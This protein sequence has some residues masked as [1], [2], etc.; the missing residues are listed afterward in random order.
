[1]LKSTIQTNQ[2]PVNFNS[3]KDDA[4]HAEMKKTALQLQRGQLMFDAF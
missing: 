4:H 3:I 2:R 1:L